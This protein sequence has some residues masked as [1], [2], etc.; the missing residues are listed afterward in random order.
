MMWFLSLIP[1]SL[2]LLVI[3]IILGLGIAGTVISFFFMPWV[4]GMAKYKSPAQIIS[5]I[6]LAGGLYWKGG[7]DLELHWRERVRELEAKVAVAEAKSKEE[8][9]K[10]ETRV[11]E[12]VKI[13]KQNVVETQVRIQKERE[14]IDKDCS[15]INPTAIELYNL[16]V[17]NGAKDE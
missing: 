3:N 2:L 10:I 5:V 14:V 16:A 12:R 11:V 17:T 15:V 4:A 13:V 1:D 8:N 9:I 7:Y 6:L